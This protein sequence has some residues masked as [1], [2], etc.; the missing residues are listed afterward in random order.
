MKL[1]YSKSITQ[2]STPK[3]LKLS[4]KGQ[5]FYTST[6]FVGDLS[7]NVTESDLAECFC[8]YGTIETAR[9]INGKP[10]GFVKFT[11]ADNAKRAISAMNGHLL[12]G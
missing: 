11:E 7:E 5:E 10:Y 9:I 12:C 6:I 8:A 1:V 2:I 4:Q 3:I